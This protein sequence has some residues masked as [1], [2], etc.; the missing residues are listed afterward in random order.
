MSD[1]SI[2]SLHLAHEIMSPTGSFGSGFK[3]NNPI[4]I[5]TTIAA[6]IAAKSAFPPHVEDYV[7]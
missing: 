7:Y 1:I 5:D 4:A 2:Q 3:N 6:T